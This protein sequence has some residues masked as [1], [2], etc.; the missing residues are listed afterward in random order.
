MNVAKEFGLV[1][2]AFFTQMCTNNCIYNNMSTV[3]SPYLQHHSLY[4]RAFLAST[5]RHTLHVFRARTL[6][7]LLELAMNQFSNIHKADVLLVNPFYKLEDQAVNS[8]SKLCSI[9]VHGQ[10]GPK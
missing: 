6:S 4:S 8:M 7:S 5:K 2:T 3:D 9:L 1:G 10:D